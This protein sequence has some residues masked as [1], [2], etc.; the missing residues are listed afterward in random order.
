MGACSHYAFNW[1]F[2]N[3]KDYFDTVEPEFADLYSKKGKDLTEPV[4]KEF[5]EL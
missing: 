3:K 4:S 2:Y 1:S 5:K